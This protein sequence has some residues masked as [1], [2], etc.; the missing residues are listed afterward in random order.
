MQ[1][2]IELSS[3]TNTKHHDLALFLLDKL[4]ENIGNVLLNNIDLVMNIILRFLSENNCLQ[5]RVLGVQALCSVLYEIPTGNILIYN[6]L[7]LI[8]SI[9]ITAINELEDFFLQ[10]MLQSICRLAKE[11]IGFFISSWEHIFSCIQLLC[12]KKELDNGVK[13]IGLEINII[14]MTYKNNSFSSTIKSRKDC[15]H[16][17]MELLTVVSDE[18]DS[19]SSTLRPESEGKNQFLM[20]FFFFYFMYKYHNFF[21]YFFAFLITTLFN[22]LVTIASYPFFLFFFNFFYFCLFIFQILFIVYLN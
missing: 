5:T 7:Q 13:V 21:L 15:L 1:G 8:S 19:I 16:L 22:Y 20:L 14:F 3:S 11:K 9:I 4:A 10:D 17:C 12:H 6:S 2:V 18:D